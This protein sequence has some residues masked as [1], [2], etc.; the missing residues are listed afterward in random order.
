MAN[1][2]III[3]LIPGCTLVIGTI[4]RVFSTHKAPTDKQNNKMRA[5]VMSQLCRIER[6]GSIVSSFVGEV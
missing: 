1:I 4:A 6:H 5:S 2:I 3:I